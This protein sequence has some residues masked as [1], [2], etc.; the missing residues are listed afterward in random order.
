VAVSRRA[1]IRYYEAFGKA[2]EKLVKRV[3]LLDPKILELSD[4]EQKEL[5]EEK[6]PLAISG[7]G[8]R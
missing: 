5:D 6:G 4:D 8:N 3:Y 1:A 2:K 7:K